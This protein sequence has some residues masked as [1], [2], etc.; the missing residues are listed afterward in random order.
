[1][2]CHGVDGKAGPPVDGFLWALKLREG[3]D[4]VFAE[5]PIF[6]KSGR[7]SNDGGFLRKSMTSS[8][9]MMLSMFIRNND[10][11]AHNWGQ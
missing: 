1:M 11:R 3:R 6:V 7:G 10:D 8:K 9:S 4:D 5:L 2:V